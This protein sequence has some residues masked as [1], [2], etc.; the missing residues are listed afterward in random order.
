M[1]NRAPPAPS[2]F[3]DVFLIKY[4]YAPIYK[5][6]IKGRVRASVDQWFLLHFF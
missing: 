1:N 2:P 5:P 4:L 3:Y 6:G